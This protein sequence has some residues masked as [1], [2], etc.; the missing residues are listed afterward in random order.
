M[1]IESTL[2]WGHALP[3]YVLPGVPAERN[4]QYSVPASFPA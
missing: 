2:V 3:H 1:S 4:D